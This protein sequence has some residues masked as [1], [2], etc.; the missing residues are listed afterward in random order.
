M[1]GG[2]YV[3]GLGAEAV[4]E[5]HAEEGAGERGPDDFAVGGVGLAEVAGGCGHGVIGGGPGGDPVVGGW[6]CGVGRRGER[7]GGRRW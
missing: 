2:P 7:G 3:E 4:G 6:V 1:C 5:L